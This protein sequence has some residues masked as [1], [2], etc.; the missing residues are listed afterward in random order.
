MLL[1]SRMLRR[2]KHAV[3]RF[4]GSASNAQ[5]VSLLRSTPLWLPK[6]LGYAL[7]GGELTREDTGLASAQDPHATQ[8]TITAEGARDLVRH[9]NTGAF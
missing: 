9:S 8:A 3:V 7:I 5:G 2:G 6:L 1:I 4:V